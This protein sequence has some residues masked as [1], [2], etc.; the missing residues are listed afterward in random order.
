MSPLKNI[1]PIVIAPIEN[2]I[3]EL[4]DKRFKKNDSN[5]SQVS[6][7]RKGKNEMKV[8]SKSCQNMKVEFEFFLMKPK[9]YDIGNVK[10]RKPIVNLSGKFQ[11]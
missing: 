3:G 9:L 7:R 1:D 5:Y 10:H 2:D 4:T 6:Q 11:Q 8:I